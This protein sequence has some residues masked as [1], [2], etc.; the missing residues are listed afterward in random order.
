MLSKKDWPQH[1]VTSLKNPN[2][3][4][5]HQRIRK[6]NIEDQHERMWTD[7][8]GVIVSWQIPPRIEL[9]AN[10]HLRENILVAARKNFRRIYR[11]V[12]AS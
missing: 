6:M 11:H 5:P 2:I 9:Q 1:Q 3:G 10:H 4:F 8:L 7:L 12:F